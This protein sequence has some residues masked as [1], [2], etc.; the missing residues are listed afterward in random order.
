MAAVASSRWATVLVVAARAWRWWAPA[1]AG[2]F[3]CR[4]RLRGPSGFVLLRFVREG[5][6]YVLSTRGRRRRRHRGTTSGAIRRRHRSS[7]VASVLVDVFIQVVCLIVFVLAGVGIVASLVG[8]H[9]TPTAIVLGDYRAGG[10]RVF[11]HAEFRRV[12]TGGALADGVRRKAPMVGVFDHVADLGGGCSRFGATIAGCLN[13]LW[14]TS[15]RFSL[16]RS[17]SG[18]RLSSWITRSVSWKPVAIES[19]G[20]GSRSAAFV[21]PGGLGVQDGAMIA[22]CALFRCSGRGRVG[23]GADQAGSRPG[24]WRT[25]IAGLASA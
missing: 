21:L 7:A 23:D 5:D 6:Q 19:L 1:S 16:A 17:K 12:R 14:F 25:V 22:V 18:S 20:Q 2:G 4:A 9:V 8:N 15:P 24:A 11:P 3:S 13:C 10:D